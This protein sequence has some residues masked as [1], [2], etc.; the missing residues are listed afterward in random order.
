MESA[1]LLHNL[2]GFQKPRIH[3]FPDTV[4]PLYFTVLLLTAVPKFFNTF[5]TFC[6]ALHFSLRITIQVLHSLIL[7]TENSKFVPRKQ[8]LLKSK[9]NSIHGKPLNS[10][11]KL[12]W[13]QWFTN[14]YFFPQDISSIAKIVTLHS[15]LFSNVQKTKLFSSP[16]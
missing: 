9:N 6:N 8:Q 4:R 14:T 16:L 10:V 11:V 7:L 3:T 1:G 5:G 12:E 13:S 15:F 2:R